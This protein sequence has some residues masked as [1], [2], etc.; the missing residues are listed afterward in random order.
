MLPA[1]YSIV[2]PTPVEAQ[3][4]AGRADADGR[5]AESRRPGTTVAVTLTGT[6]FIAGATTVTVSGAACRSRTSP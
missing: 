3:S 1:I 2:A 6:N 4:P 5:L